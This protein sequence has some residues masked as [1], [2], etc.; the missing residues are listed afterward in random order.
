MGTITL[1]EQAQRKS[2]ILTRL[3]AGRMTPAEA[4]QLLGISDRHLR[5]LRVRF[6]REGVACVV[7]GNSHKAPKHK[8]G[9]EVV[10]TLIGLAGEGGPYLGFNVCH[11][12]DLLEERHGIAIG[13]STLSRLLLEQGIT[14]RR[15]SR[16]AARRHARRE[17]KSA[18]GMLVQMDGSLHDWLEGRG[19]RLCL[20]G[21][22]DDA[23]GRVLYLRFHE[24]ESQE[25]Y[26]LLLRQVAR[27]HGLPMAVYHDRHTILR[28]PKKA[29]IEDELAGREPMSQV[30]RV[31]HE[32]GIESIAAL[33]PQAKGRVERLWGTLQDRLLKEMRLGGIAD[34]ETAN[35]FLTAFITRFN[36][37]FAVPAA[38][39]QAAFVPLPPDCDVGYYFAVREDRT[40][41]A[42]QSLSFY[43]KTLLLESKESRAGQK[44]AVHRLPE[45]DLL[46][47]AGKR[48]VPFRIVPV[49][50]PAVS[51]ASKPPSRRPA[52]AAAEPKAKARQRAWLY[53]DRTR[54]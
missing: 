53:A 41:K 1:S 18:E 11:L 5:R 35:L 36:A 13:R 43:G 49:P 3:C 37:R 8:T 29:S 23:T 19:P 42:D 38:D 4:A 40:V 22:I 39:E 47:F 24:S 50:P 44:V 27:E 6:E 54:T 2:D 7:H 48:R 9:K 21:A 51:P 17:R 45:G 33:S 46:V 14:T 28:S 30:Q 25:A 31:L 15:R 52:P 20:I 32:L 26:L 34:K 16:K 12:H 10:E